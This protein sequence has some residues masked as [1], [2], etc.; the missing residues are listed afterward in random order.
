MSEATH[1]P[2]P[3]KTVRNNSID[4]GHGRDY[5]IVF[6]KSG[7][8][9]AYCPPTDGDNGNANAAFIQLAVNCHE[10]LVA[11]LE[12]LAMAWDGAEGAFGGVTQESADRL[13]EAYDEA[14]K[15]LAKA[16]VQPK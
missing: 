4:L 16:K 11:A 8:D 15:V 5:R 2:T 13:D 9:V 1:L 14:V 3:W 10:Q 12:N 7:K 6:S